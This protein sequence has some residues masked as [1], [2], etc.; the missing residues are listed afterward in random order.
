MPVPNRHRSIGPPAQQNAVDHRRRAICTGHSGPGWQYTHLPRQIHACTRRDL[1]P[2]PLPGSTQ[3]LLMTQRRRQLMHPRRRS[4][5]STVQQAVHTTQTRVPAENSH[6]AR[7]EVWFGPHQIMYA[8]AS[9]GLCHSTRSRQILIQCHFLRRCK[10][11]LQQQRHKP[12]VH[13]RRQ[14][15]NWTRRKASATS[16]QLDAVWTA[17]GK[18]NFDQLTMN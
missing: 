2:S 13:I 16:P 11:I 14:N 18:Y 6:P 4:I 3:R 15:S 10:S 8:V 5:D 7:A 1:S 9:P 12:T 17:N